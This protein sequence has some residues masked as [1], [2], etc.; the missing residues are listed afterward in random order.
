MKNKIFFT[1]G[2]IKSGTTLVQ[3][4]LDI[5]PDICCRKEQDLNALLK[6]FIT[7]GESLKPFVDGF[8]LKNYFPLMI[9]KILAN[10]CNKKLMGLKEN[11]FLLDNIYEIFQIFEDVKI[12][13]IVRNPI[14]N[15][16]SWWD[17]HLRLTDLGMIDQNIDQHDFLISNAKM[18]SKINEKIISS[19]QHYPSD[20]LIVR[21]EDI[22]AHKVE[23]LEKIC[24][25]LD[26]NLNKNIIDDIIKRTAFSKMK[27]D[28]K[29]PS[30]YKKARS[31]YGKSSNL[32]NKIKFKIEAITLKER[33][34]LN[35]L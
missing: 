2:I 31:D 29:D 25:F 18:W 19:S 3:K 23:I 34:N 14:D 8:N 11:K 32:D 15:L 20:I 9:E 1:G 35:Y 33:E 12:I 27:S 28:S 13:F 22:L 7:E 26:V 6:F 21:Y 17:H 10:N 5:H 30:F 4:M 24:S 16:L